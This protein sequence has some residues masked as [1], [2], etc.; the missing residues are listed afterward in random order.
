MSA[1]EREHYKSTFDAEFQ[2]GMKY[3]LGECGGWMHG[4]ISESVNFA[5]N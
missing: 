1:I 5:K 3:W 2:V 4:L